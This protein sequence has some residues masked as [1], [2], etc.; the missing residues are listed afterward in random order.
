[1][2]TPEHTSALWARRAAV[3][4]DR[5]QQTIDRAGVAGLDMTLDQVAALAQVQALLAIHAELK[6]INQSD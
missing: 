6:R 4:M 2:N 1:M 5:V 3:M